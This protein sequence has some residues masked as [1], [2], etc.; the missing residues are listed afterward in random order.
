MSYSPPTDESVKG[1]RRLRERPILSVVVPCY[2]EEEVLPILFARLASLETTLMSQDLISGPIELVLVDD[3]SSDATWDVILKGQT[4][5]AI[6]AV[7]LSCNC[8]HQNALVAGLEKASGDIAISMDADLQDDPGAIVGMVR[9][10]FDGAEIVYGVRV[11]RHSDTWFKR[12][13]ARAY[14][15]A[16]RILGVD[17]IPD[18]ADFRLMS[19]KALSALREFDETNLFLR[20]LVRKLGFPSA[21]VTYDRGC[22][23][24]GRSSYSLRKMMS[25]AV[26]GVTSLS[27]HP[28]RI[29]AITG[30]SMSLIA[31]IL[32]FLAVVAWFA[33]ET[34]P[35]WTSIVLPMSLLS[36]IH[37]LALGIIGEYVGKIYQE[38]KRR[39]RYI[40]EDVV[41]LQ[42]PRSRREPFDAVDLATAA[43]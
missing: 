14:Y 16:L 36:G 42:G 21:I 8:G 9:A 22:R 29:I 11:S 40:L 31:F 32:G 7:K 23:G 12:N 43:E 33:G 30:L 24:A 13:S 34:V 18:H 1:T 10:Y 19:R 37:L 35:G 17:L 38:T 26:E 15:K 39:P 6:T 5:L 25:L 3:G 41:L 20:G 4:K 27:I 2:N 28:L